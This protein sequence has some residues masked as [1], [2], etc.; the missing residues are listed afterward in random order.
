MF[1][2]STKARRKE[3]WLF[4][5]T[6]WQGLEYLYQQ[7]ERAEKERALKGAYVWIPDDETRRYVRISLG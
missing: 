7:V 1:D 6:V 2:F 5:D 4:L 3:A